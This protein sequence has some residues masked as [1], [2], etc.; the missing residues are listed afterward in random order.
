M[1]TSNLRAYALAGAV[2]ASVSSLAIAA[3]KGDDEG[4]AK[5][6]APVA[7]VELAPATA[8]AAAGSRSGEQIYKSICAA[9]HDS[10]AANAPK[11]GDKAAWAARIKLGLDGLVKSAIAGK[12]AMPPKGGSDANEVEMARV[13][14]FIANKSGASFKEPAAK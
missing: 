12:N 6:I 2:L 5:R 1:V 8:G 4:A 3:P 9:C 13:V 10:G 14:A 11:L 7:R